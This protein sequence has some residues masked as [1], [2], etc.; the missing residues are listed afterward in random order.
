MLHRLGVVRHR[1]MLHTVVR[2]PATRQLDKPSVALLHS[3]TFLASDSTTLYSA[4]LP[5]SCAENL[6][7]SIHNG[8]SLPWWMT[9]AV[10]TITLR[11]CITLPLTI[12][13]QK[14]SAKLVLLQPVVKEISEAVKYNVATKCR[15]EDLPVEVAEER[16]KTL[17]SGMVRDL[18]K[19]E[20]CQPFK[21]F[22]LPWTQMPLWI[23]ISLGLRDLSIYKQDP[24]M[25]T[26][27]LAWF[28]NLLLPDPAWILPICF[29]LCNLLNIEINAAGRQAPGRI[30][31]IMKKIFV[32]LSIVMVPVATQIPSCMS[33]Y[34]TLSSFYSLV[35]NSILMLPRVKRIARIPQTP[36]ESK[37]PFRDL[38]AI[39]SIRM[40]KFI[41]LQ[42]QANRK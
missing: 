12:Y 32:T 38:Y 26:E 23:S 33:F 30:Q 4:Y 41:Q 29:G 11:T 3:S 28:S 40:K 35:Q 6:L 36:K 39:F 5:V 13:Q 14:K 15:R 16:Y 31:A 25:A 1:V 21:L 34:W 7:E 22:L 2:S 9:I 37:H 8:L 24:A 18:Y 10:T 17:F 20:G 19:K 42:K 27:G